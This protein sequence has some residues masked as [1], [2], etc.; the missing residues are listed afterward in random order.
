MIVL[1]EC[2]K[3]EETFNKNLKSQHLKS[4]LKLD[5]VEFE[6]G[7]LTDNID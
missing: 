7:Y 2:F 4:F 5:L 3:N 6:K 1:W